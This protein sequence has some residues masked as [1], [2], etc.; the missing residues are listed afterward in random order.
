MVAALA[1]D[2]R[3][4]VEQPGTPLVFPQVGPELGRVETL[5]LLGREVRDPP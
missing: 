2:V 1:P 5:L 3:E 4:L